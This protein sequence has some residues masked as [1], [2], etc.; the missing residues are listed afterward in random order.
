MRMFAPRLR[1]HP[2]RRRSFSAFQP[3]STHA[4]HL[5]QSE[6]QMPCFLAATV[7]AKAS[8]PTRRRQT[9]VRDI[10]GGQRC[11]RMDLLCD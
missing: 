5:C 3:P 6:L 4:A 8:R 9:L 11:I 1:S 10:V 7:L 2:P